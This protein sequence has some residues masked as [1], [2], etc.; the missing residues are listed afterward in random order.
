MLK[1]GAECLIAVFTIRRCSGKLWALFA[2]GTTCC[3]GQLSFG[4]LLILSLQHP[5]LFLE[6]QRS[7]SLQW[8]VPVCTE[9]D[10][11]GTPHSQNRSQDSSFNC[12]HWSL[13]INESNAVTELLL[14]SATTF[15]KLNAEF[16][17]FTARDIY[18]IPYMLSVTEPG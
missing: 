1:C 2:T 4:L 16:L 9:S 12:L 5:L 10:S 18:L 8:T 6:I 17:F 11:S 15:H 14:F 13:L 7:V 3:S